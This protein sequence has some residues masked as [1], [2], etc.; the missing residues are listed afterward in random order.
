M[1]TSSADW[2]RCP[3][4]G[5]PLAQFILSDVEQGLVFGRIQCWVCPML[6]EHQVGP[7]Q[8]NQSTAPMAA[9]LQELPPGTISRFHKEMER[10][11]EASHLQ[12]PSTEILPHWPGPLPAAEEAGLLRLADDLIASEETHRIPRARR[13]KRRSLWRWLR[14][15]G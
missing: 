11:R 9:F 3:V 1:D 10:V 12:G 15:R 7:E 6:Q 13:R 14:R 5:I 2:P 4:H 8:E